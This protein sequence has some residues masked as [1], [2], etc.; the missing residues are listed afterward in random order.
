MGECE[1]LARQGT[2]GFVL[3]LFLLLLLLLVLFARKLCYFSPFFAL[4]S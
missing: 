1:V 4:L 2:F 3:L